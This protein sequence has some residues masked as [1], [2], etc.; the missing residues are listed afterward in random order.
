MAPIVAERTHPILYR[1]IEPLTATLPLQSANRLPAL[2]NCDTIVASVNTISN[3]VA[4]KDP[5]GPRAYRAKEGIPMG[6]FVYPPPASESAWHCSRHSHNTKFCAKKKS[7]TPTREMADGTKPPKGTTTVWGKAK[8]PPPTV[9]P[10]IRSDAFSI[11]TDGSTVS[12]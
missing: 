3:A 10:A 8:N 1:A 4:R 12:D 5:P 2:D 11:C 6:F 9:V 7:Q